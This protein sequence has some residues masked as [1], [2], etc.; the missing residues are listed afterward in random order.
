LRSGRKIRRRTK[1]M[2]MVYGFVSQGRRK[3]ERKGAG[4]R[5]E[6]RGEERKSW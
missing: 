5:G 2:H 6:E 1:N 3:N 4:E